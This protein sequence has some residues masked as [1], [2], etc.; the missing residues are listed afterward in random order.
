MKIPSWLKADHGIS[1]FLP[2]HGRGEALPRGMKEIL[3]AKPGI[4]DLPELIEFGGPLESFGL[5]QESQSKAAAFVG[6]KKGWYGVNGASGLLQAALFSLVQPGQSVLMPRNV[7][8]SIA[9]ACVLGGFQ[10]ILFD[11]PYLEDRGHYGVPNTAWVKNVIENLSLDKSQIAAAVLVNPSYQGYS[12]DISGQIEL[13]H[14]IGWPVLVDEAHGAYFAYGK[15]LG[16]PPSSLSSGADLVVHSLHKSSIGLAQT[17]ALWLQGEIVDPDLVQRSLGLLM[18]SSPSSLFIASCESAVLY[19]STSKG[20]KI[21]EDRIKKAKTI[22][23]NLKSAGI[24][25]LENQDPFRIILHTAPIGITGF[26]ADNW[27][28][29]RGIIA[30]L[31][32][33]G[34]LTFCLGFAQHKRLI[35]RF[36]RIWDQLLKSAKGRESID[37]FSRPP[38]PLI[39]CPNINCGKAWRSNYKIVHI[40]K[41]SGCISTEIICPYPPGI[42]L[43]FPGEKL[44]QERIEWLLTQKALW[45]DNIPTYLRVMNLNNPLS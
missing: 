5:V 8:K 24:P 17:A 28:S 25:L 23:N 42:P 2:A 6:A 34:C 30:E 43:V 45:P 13:F 14:Q 18:T 37:V 12:A 33:P 10:P 26:E 44:N 22:F 19:W 31:P 7:H 41:A 38:I 32:E 20:Q 1:L 16:T 3:R 21:L 27:F 36:K 4:W 9:H 40:T 35:H 39:S 15:G 11:I 29:S